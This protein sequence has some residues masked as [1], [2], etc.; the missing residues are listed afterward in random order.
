MIRTFF[1]I[2]GDF[3]P[4]DQFSGAV[5]DSDYIE[6]AIVCQIGGCEIFNMDHW[7]LVDQLWAYIVQGLRKLDEGEIYETFFPDQ[8]LRMRFE[9][10]G[11]QCSKITLG[12]ESA[13]V[14]AATFRS[15]MKRGAVEFFSRMKEIVPESKETWSHYQG[16]AEMIRD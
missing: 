16:E 14:D 10:I 6:G 8:P 13:D 15:V 2:D 1:R 5:P 9:A 4:I 3:V 11:P 12:G 7:D